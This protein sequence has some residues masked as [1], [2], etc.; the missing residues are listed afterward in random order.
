MLK[1]MAIIKFAILT[2]IGTVI[3]SIAYSLLGRGRL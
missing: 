1:E 3:S 2:M